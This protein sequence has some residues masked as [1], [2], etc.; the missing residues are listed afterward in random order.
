MK[1]RKARDRDPRTLESKEQCQLQA[2]T[3]ESDAKR[4]EL[5]RALKSALETQV[6]VCAD[7]KLSVFSEYV[8]RL[9]NEQEAKHKELEQ[10]RCKSDVAEETM[11]ATVRLAKDPLEP[12]DI[13]Q[14]TAECQ[15]MTPSER[16]LVTMRRHR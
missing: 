1:K 2:V 11:S 7:E 15:L 13:A 3:C 10:L 5:H 6:L 8:G 9:G 14:L 4:D 16:R 12:H